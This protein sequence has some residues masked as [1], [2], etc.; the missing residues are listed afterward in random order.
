MR[1][2]RRLCSGRYFNIL[3]ISCKKVALEV[4]INEIIDANRIKP[5]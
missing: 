3:D 4:K 2:L 5:F 1:N